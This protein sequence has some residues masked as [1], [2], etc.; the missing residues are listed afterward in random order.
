[1][2][3]RNSGC[4]SLILGG[5]S[6]ISDRLLEGAQP[7]P[8]YDWQA[9]LRSTSSKYDPNAERVKLFCD[10]LV[11]PNLDRAEVLE[12][13]PDAPTKTNFFRNFY[14]QTTARVEA[15]LDGVLRRLIEGRLVNEHYE[16]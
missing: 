6:L 5:A 10:A 14:Q 11:Q 4:K 7:H 2:A 8:Q 9:D 13:F 15:E 12:L 16:N 3:P 1:M